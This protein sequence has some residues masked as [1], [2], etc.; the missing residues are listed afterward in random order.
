MK[1]MIL[2]AGE[3]TRLRPITLEIPKV[4]V[5]IDG[6]P[7]I[8]YTLSWL[9]SYGISEVAINLCYL[10]EKVKAFL[11]DGSRFGMRI[12]YSEEK[13]LLGTA[14]GL[15]KLE[16][17]FDGPFIVVYGDILIQFNLSEMISFHEQK[18]ALATIA[19]FKP[20]NPSEVG[21]IKLDM[22]DRVISL[23]EKPKHVD[24]TQPVLAN[25]GVYVF[26]KEIFAYMPGNGFCDFAYDIYPKLVESG[27]QVYG[28]GL[29]PNDYLM[30]I[31][32]LEKHRK[33][34]EDIRTGKIKFQIDG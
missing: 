15:K 6:I 2:A 4:L 28:Y 25:A 14:G 24:Q 21:I 31:G 11:G 29:K 3:G 26:E 33:A 19:L 10:G 13:S 12:V 7:L 8:Q 27:A 20:L 32:S 9:K 34:N 1:A 23:I 17:F 22:D 30:D 18:K 16:W 5:P